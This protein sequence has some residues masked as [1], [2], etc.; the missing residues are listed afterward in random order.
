MDKGEN[1]GKGNT[2][3]LD[4]VINQIESYL[5]S[6]KQIATSAM[7]EIEKNKAVMDTRVEMYKKY[8]SKLTSGRL[9]KEDSEKYFVVQFKW[10]TD[11][12][13]SDL[14]NMRLTYAKHIEALNF[15]L[16]GLKR[17]REEIKKREKENKF[18]RETLIVILGLSSD[19]SLEEIETRAEELGKLTKHLIKKRE[20]WEAE[21]KEKEKW[22]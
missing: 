13:K 1:E 7:I 12:S 15:L 14:D 18:L 22:R 21:E 8:I 3:S 19:A 10:L 20:E 4:S 9:S 6:A 2:E 17:A 5:K 11:L 16:G